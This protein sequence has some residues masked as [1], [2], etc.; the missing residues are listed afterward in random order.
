MIFCSVLLAVVFLIIFIVS[1]RNGQFD[2][3]ESPAVRI[4]LESEIIK[5][6]PETEKEL[7][8][9]TEEKKVINL[10]GNSKI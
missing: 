10:Y 4:L 1:A 7:G 2:D 6:K 3:D 8:V 5:E 9:P